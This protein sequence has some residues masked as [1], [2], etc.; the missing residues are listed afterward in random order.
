[1]ISHVERPYNYYNVWLA[2]IGAYAITRY[3]RHNF[4][5]SVRV[6]HNITIMIGIRDKKETKLVDS[7]V[8]V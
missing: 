3:M 1:M 7:Q 2:I 4:T 5:K 8:R 6:V